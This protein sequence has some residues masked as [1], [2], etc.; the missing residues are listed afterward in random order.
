MLYR[1]RAI[2]DLGH[3]F[4]GDAYP[5][6]RTSLSIKDSQREQHATQPPSTAGFLLANVSA[7]VLHCIPLY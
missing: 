6:P 2:P 3:G 4:F 1:R 5:V 7:S